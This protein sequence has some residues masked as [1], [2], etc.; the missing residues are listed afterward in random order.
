MADT[1]GSNYGM[2]SLPSRSGNGH[3]AI[4]GPARTF[5]LTSEQI[6]IPS[7]LDRA[8]LSVY[9]WIVTKNKGKSAADVLTVEIRDG[10]GTLLETLATY[11]NLDAG[12]AYAQRRFDVSRYRGAT[13]RI[14][15]TGIQSQ[16]PP[17]WFL[18]DDAALK[19][20]K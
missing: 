19:I 17:T 10:A 2:W 4:G 7:T 14:S 13:I 16:G 1:G 5:Y 15:F 12:P 8:E 20:W 6:T 11:S 18:L 3:A 9:L